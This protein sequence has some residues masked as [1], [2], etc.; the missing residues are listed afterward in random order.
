MSAVNYFL[1]RVLWKLERITVRSLS[2]DQ[3]RN[4]IE[5][6]SKRP[7]IPPVLMYHRIDPEVHTE[8]SVTPENFARQVNIL[9]ELGY[10][11]L[12][13]DEWGVITGKN[14]LLTF[15]DGYICNYK[16][17]YPVMR[18]EGIKATINVI[19]NRL[20]DTADDKCFSVDELK[21]MY[22]SGLISFEAH[23]VTHKK[24]TECREDEL[25]YELAA[26]KDM[27]ENETGIIM[28]TIVYPQNAVNETV[29]KAACNFYKR[30]FSCIELK[31]NK[32][33]LTYRIPRVPIF[34]EMTERDFLAEIYL[35]MLYCRYD[36]CINK[37]LKRFR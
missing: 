25:E 20:I 24:L 22:Q 19:A 15:D 7:H 26:V 14:I 8:L 32:V 2:V 4:R 3:L 28:S 27:I 11:F 6:A 16:Y 5:K 35:Y 30:G 10:T 9:K 29:Y 17:A 18:E 33:P 1:S 23:T 21:E 34:N 36:R 13:E 12:F 37:Y 31:E